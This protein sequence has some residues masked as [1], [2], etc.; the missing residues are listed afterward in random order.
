MET[1][2]SA[3]CH[4]CGYEFQVS[5]RGGFFGLPL[6]CDRCSR[7]TYVRLDDIHAIYA[8]FQ[9]QMAA[10]RLQQEAEDDLLACAAFERQSLALEDAYEAE[11]EASLAPCLCGGRFRFKRDTPCPN[12]GSVRY[13]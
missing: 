8:R 5:Q 7:E 12:C 2:Y 1:L 10:L 13:Y 11:V 4:A 3:T 9:A 6:Q